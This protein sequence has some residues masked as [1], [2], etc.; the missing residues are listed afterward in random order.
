MLMQ[1]GL[2]RKDQIIKAIQTKTIC[3][4]VDLNSPTAIALFNDLVCLKYD[5]ILNTNNSEGSVLFFK[6]YCFRHWK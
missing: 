1:F 3:R 4:S 2:L 5:Q 6:D